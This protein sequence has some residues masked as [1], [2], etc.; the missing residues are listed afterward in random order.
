MASAARRRTSASP[1]PRAASVAIASP[2]PQRA[3][4]QGRRRAAADCTHANLKHVHWNVVGP[5]FVDVHEMIGPQVDRVREMADDVAER[6]AALGGVAQGTPGA[7][8]TERTW[9]N[10]SSAG[11]TP[12]PTSARST[13]STR[14]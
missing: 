14:K 5:H 13:S 3:A 2:T 11:P 7:L 8:V 4:A 10:Y 12:S 9:D 6:I 1:P